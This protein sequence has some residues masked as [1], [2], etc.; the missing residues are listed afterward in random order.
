MNDLE[1][2]KKALD[3][4]SAGAALQQPLV[5]AQLKVPPLQLVVVNNA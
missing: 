1:Q 5:R 3:M 4:A 2:L